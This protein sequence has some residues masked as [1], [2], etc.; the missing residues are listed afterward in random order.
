MNKNADVPHH[1]P[2]HG[3]IEDDPLVRGRGRY[4]DDVRPDGAA[5]ACFVRSVII[6]AILDALP[7]DARA[8][9]ER[10]ATVERVWRALQPAG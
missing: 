7:K 3:R 5:Y 9:L 6:N 8:N 10:P 4:S 1:G 2:W